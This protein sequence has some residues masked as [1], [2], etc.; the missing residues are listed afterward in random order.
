MAGFMFD[1]G[2]S[3]FFS[4]LT[5]Y[6]SIVS[7]LFTEVQTNRILAAEYYMLLG[8][9]RTTPFTGVNTS[10]TCK[11]HAN[12]TSFPVGLRPRNQG[13]VSRS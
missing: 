12:Y 3:E 6:P 11:D 13:Y 7:E 9:H 2:Q 4:V 5:R 10:L 1:P 8:G